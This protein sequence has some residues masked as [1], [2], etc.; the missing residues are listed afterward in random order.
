MPRLWLIQVCSCRPSQDYA[1]TLT[2]LREHLE[3]RSWVLLPASQSNPVCPKSSPAEPACPAAESTLTSNGIP[4][5]C[6]GKGNSPLHLIR[7][8]VTLEQGTG[9]IFLSREVSVLTP[10]SKPPAQDELISYQIILK[11]LPCRAG[12]STYQS[13]KTPKP[14]KFLLVMPHGTSRHNAQADTSSAPAE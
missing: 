4:D 6:Q 13:L 14:A 3:E 1:A 10:P 11:S 8:S 5:Y 9:G 2:R 12:T 7:Q